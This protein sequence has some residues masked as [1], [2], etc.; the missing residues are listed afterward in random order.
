[1]RRTLFPLVFVSL[2][3]LIAVAA[4]AQMPMPKPAP[5]LSKLDFMVGTWITDS[6]LKPGPMGPGGKMTSVD[7]VQWMEG[8]FYQVVRSKFKGA[9]GD[10]ESLAVFGY[11]PEKKVYTYNDFSMGE[12]GYSEGTV[13]GDTWTWNGDQ[14]MGDQTF[15]GRFTMKVVSPTLYTFKYEMSKDG[16]E[17]ATVMEGKSTKK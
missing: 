13:D 11:N 17:W 9:M 8:K 15:K 12:A 3:I 6:D 5:E 2:M 7:E 16:T 14:K 10:G 4:Q 1:M